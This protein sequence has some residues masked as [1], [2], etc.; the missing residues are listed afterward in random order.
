MIRVIIVL[1]LE[2]FYGYYV[3]GILASFSDIQTVLLACISTLLPLIIALGIAF[4]VRYANS[5]HRERAL[6]EASVGYC[7]NRAQ[8]TIALLSLSL[9]LSLLFLLNAPSASSQARLAKIPKREEQRQRFTV[10]ERLHLR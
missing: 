2:G 9:S 1:S 3:P 8:S 7:F 10:Q 5:A 6:S 4:G